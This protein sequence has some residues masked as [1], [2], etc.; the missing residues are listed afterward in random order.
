MQESGD[1]EEFWGQPRSNLDRAQFRG[2][3]GLHR[4]RRRRRPEELTRAGNDVRRTARGDDRHG[5]R[6]PRTRGAR[7]AHTVADAKAAEAAAAGRGTMAS[8]AVGLRCGDGGGLRRVWELAGA[9][10]G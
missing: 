3:P 1:L 4:G 2:W 10:G 7:R 8:V 6:S 5:G 9:G